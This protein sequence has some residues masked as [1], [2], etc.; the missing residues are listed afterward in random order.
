MNEIVGQTPKPGASVEDGDEPRSG[1]SIVMTPTW[2][3]SLRLASTCYSVPEIINPVF[4]K[5][6]PKRSF[7]VT[8]YERFGLVFT[9]TRVYKFGHR[10]MIKLTSAIR[11]TFEIMF[12]LL[13]HVCWHMHWGSSSNPGRDL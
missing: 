7:S 8:E 13:V 11:S 1:F 6:S 9:K 4:A 5:T 10:M 3:N 2:S 12:P